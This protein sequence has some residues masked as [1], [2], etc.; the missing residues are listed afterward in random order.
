M[1]KRHRPLPPECGIERQHAVE[2]VPQPVGTFDSH[3]GAVGLHL[4]W[5]Q[6][7]VRVGDAG[8]CV[9]RNRNDVF[10]GPR[11]CQVRAARVATV[12]SDQDIQWPEESTAHSL[13]LS[14]VGN[15]VAGPQLSSVGGT[16]VFRRLGRGIRAEPTH[17]HSHQDTHI[18]DSST[19]KGGLLELNR[20]SLSNMQQERPCTVSR[21]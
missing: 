12:T 11:S 6:A 18:A 9:L 20:Y 16:G 14:M 1:F 15:V 8:D 19:G 4:W 17:P 2:A 5:D 3:S 7:Q 21:T 13:D 10:G